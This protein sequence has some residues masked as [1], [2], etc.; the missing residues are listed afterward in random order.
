MDV[1]IWAMLRE[2]RKEEEKKDTN[3]GTGRRKC[4]RSQ[5]ERTSGREHTRSVKSCWREIHQPDHSKVTGF[6]V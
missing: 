4:H 5:K 3:R 6:G 2:F 1:H